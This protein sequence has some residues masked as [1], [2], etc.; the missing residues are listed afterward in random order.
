[1]FK[2]AILGI[3]V[4]CLW[5]IAAHAAAAR[6]S[7]VTAIVFHWLPAAVAAGMAAAL[8]LGGAAFLLSLAA[9]G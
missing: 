5:N 3:A 8:A 2:L 9:A 6:S 1:M 4:L 7:E